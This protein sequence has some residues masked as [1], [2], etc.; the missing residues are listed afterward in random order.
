MRYFYLKRDITSIICPNE[1]LRGCARSFSLMLVI[2]VVSVQQF[3]DVVC[4]DTCCDRDQ[5]AYRFNHMSLLSVREE[6]DNKENIPY[7]EKYNN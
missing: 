7:N 3:A 4:N 5:E 1:K 2:L 6:I